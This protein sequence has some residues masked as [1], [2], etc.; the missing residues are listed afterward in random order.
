MTLCFHSV[1]AATIRFLTLWLEKIT[2]SINELFQ[3]QLHCYQEQRK[4]D[5][6]NQFYSTS[7]QMSRDDITLRRW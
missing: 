5:V 6:A 3:L 2:R 7:T 1:E 4:A